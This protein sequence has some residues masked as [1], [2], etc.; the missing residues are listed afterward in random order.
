L[1]DTNALGVIHTKSD[2]IGE[3]VS[4]GQRLTPLDVQGG[5]GT[6]KVGEVGYAEL[7]PYKGATGGGMTLTHTI[8][9]VSSC[10]LWPFGD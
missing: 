9:A 5:K 4:V 8:Q 1:D 6:I 10:P 7:E 2:Q 3:V